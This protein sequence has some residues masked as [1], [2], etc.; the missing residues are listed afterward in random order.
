[1]ETTSCEQVFYPQST[2]V[3]CRGVSSILGRHPIFV[4]SP[5]QFNADENGRY[6]VLTCRHSGCSLCG[7]EGSYR[8]LAF[9]FQ[10]PITVG[11]QKLLPKAS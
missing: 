7:V 2:Y 9:G 3:W 8:E 11:R 5:V 1:M 6:A 4:S 10:D